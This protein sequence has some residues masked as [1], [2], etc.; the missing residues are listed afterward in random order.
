M[1]RVLLTSFAAKAAKPCVSWMALSF[2][3]PLA[4]NFA[5]G[6]FGGRGEDNPHGWGLAW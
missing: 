1:F 2:A 6:P 5:V 4:T 3:R